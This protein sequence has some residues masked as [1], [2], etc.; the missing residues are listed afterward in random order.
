MNRNVRS[1]SL[2]ELLEQVD[3]LRLDRDVQRRD[4]LVGDDE[5]GVHRER[6]RDADRAAAGRPRT[7]AGTAPRPRRASP[8]TFSSS[9]DAVPARARRLHE[10]VDAQRLADEPTDR[11]PRVQRRERVLEDH[12]HPPAQRAQLALAEGRDVVAVED[13]SPA[14]G[15]YRR[16]KR[17]A[18]RRLAAPG[19]ADEAERL[20]AADRE[21]DVVDRPHVADVP[22][23]QDARLDREPDAKVVDLDEVLVVAASLRLLSKDR[24]G[25]LALT[26]A[27]S[28]ALAVHASGSTG[29]KQA[30]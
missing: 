16:S 1:N 20:A 12:L 23:E 10:P 17:A 5:V 2:L 11:V 24:V 4:G 21:G 19:L 27:G 7:R 8:T 3:D 30:T 13:D 9:R 6:A 28:R 25:V 15:A 14:V 26:R 22:I 18:D 29:L